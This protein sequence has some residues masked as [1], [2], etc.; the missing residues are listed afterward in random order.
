MRF[1]PTATVAWRSVVDADPSRMDRSELGAVLRALQVVRSLCDAVELDVTARTRKLADTGRSEPVEALLVNET[2]RSARDA[3]RAAA[4][5]TACD[6]APGLQA[7]LADGTL[8]GGHLDAVATAIGR[9]EGDDVVAEF[10]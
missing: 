4:R 10:A 8:T 7:A 5:N 2:G 9:L 6:A 3:R 1:T